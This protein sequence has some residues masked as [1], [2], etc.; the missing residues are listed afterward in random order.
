MVNGLLIN[1]L[2]FIKGDLT[3]HGWWFEI[4]KANVYAFS[5]KKQKFVLMDDKKVEELL[6]RLEKNENEESSML[7]D[8]P[9]WVKG[10]NK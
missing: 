4:G 3:L 5:E 10:L 1:K 8:E 9:N 6:E 7:Q 2:F